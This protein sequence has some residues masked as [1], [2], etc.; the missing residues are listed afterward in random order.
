LPATVLCSYCDQGY[1]SHFTCVLGSL[2]PYWHTINEGIGYK[3]KFS[4]TYKVLPPDYLYNLIF[5]KCACRT[6]S[7][8]VVTLAQPAVS[9]SL[10]Q[11]LVI[12][13]SFRYAPP[14]L[15]NQPPSSFCQPNLFTLLVY[16]ILH[17]SPHHSTLLRCHQ[18]LLLSLLLRTK[19][20]SF[21]QIFSW[22]VFLVSFGL[23]SWILDFDW[24][25]WTLAFACF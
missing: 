1:F 4:L 16:I 15:W 11:I 17:I 7:S 20:S 2:Y 18:L 9:S 8:S 10:L 5:V 24:T 13:C 3:C 23:I 6:C 12:N 19:T 22:I 25:K 21:S 14:Y